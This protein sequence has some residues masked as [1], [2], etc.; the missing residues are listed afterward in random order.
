ML[1][2]KNISTGI[3]IAFIALLFA[4]LRFL[5]GVSRMAA[6]LELLLFV[7]LLFFAVFTVLFVRADYK[8]FMWFSTVFFSAGMLNFIVLYFL[9]ANTLLFVFAIVISAAGLLLSL[10]DRVGQTREKRAPKIAKKNVPSPDVQVYESKNVKKT[11]IPGKYVASKW[12]NVYHAANSEWAKKMKKKN[13]IWFPSEEEA[14]KSGRRP[15]R[16]LSNDS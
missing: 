12:G 10:T 15:H 2:S 6:I 4:H 5:L 3:I 7:L 13:M 9:S 11:F 8:R 16:D 1:M 14:K